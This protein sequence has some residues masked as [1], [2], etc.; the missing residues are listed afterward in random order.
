MKKCYFDI[1]IGLEKYFD[2]VDYERILEILSVYCDQVIIELLYKF[3]KFD[4]LDIFNFPIKLFI[5][6][7]AL[8][9]VVFISLNHK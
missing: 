4:Y 3:L 2:K 6:L 5:I 8:Y 9:E 7:K 1:S